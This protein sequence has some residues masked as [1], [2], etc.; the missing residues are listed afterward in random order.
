MQ[1]E[2]FWLPVHE[3]SLDGCCFKGCELLATAAVALIYSG[4]THSFVSLAVVDKHGLPV[5]QV[6]SMQVT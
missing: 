2:P 1:V 3:P 4:M 5:H 6:D